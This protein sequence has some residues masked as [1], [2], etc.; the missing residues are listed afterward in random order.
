MSA[1][2][3]LIKQ[4]WS[5]LTKAKTLEPLINVLQHANV[6]PMIRLR[7]DAF[8]STDTIYL[9]EIFKQLRTSKLV[10]RSSFS[11]EDSA[12]TSMAGI[13]TSVTNV[14]NTEQLKNA[15]Q[16]VFNS[17]PQNFAHSEEVLIQ[18]MAK[19][20]A[21]CGVIFTQEQ[22]TSAPY[23]IISDDTSGQTDTVTSGAQGDIDTYYVRRGTEPRRPLLKLLL[24]L[25]N[26]LMQGFQSTTLDIEYAID[27]GGNVWLF[28]VRTLI[29]VNKRPSI[30]HNLVA[31]NNIYEKIKLSMQVHPFLFGSST[32]FGVMPDWNPAEI[33]GLYPKPLALSLYKS[34]ITDSTWAYQRHN[35]GYRNLRSFPLMVDFMG[36]PYIDVRVSF[37]SF[38]PKDISPALGNKLVDYYLEQLRSNPKSHDSVEF[39]IVL[40]C[41]TPSLENK[42]LNLQKHGFSTSQCSEISSHLRNLTNKIIDPRTGLWIQDLHRIEKLKQRY[43]QT[44]QGFSEPVSRIYWLLEDCKRYGTLPFA[45]LARAAFIAVQLM[46][47]ML[48]NKVLT[49]EEYH[50]FLGSLKTVSSKMQSDLTRLSKTQFLNEY[51]HL[52]PGTYDISSPRYDDAPEYYFDWDQFDKFEENDD[53]STYSEGLK[54]SISPITYARIEAMLTEHGINHSADSLLHFI[55]SA[56]EGREY[57]KFIFTRSLSDAMEEF[58]LLGEQLGFTRNQMAFSNINIINQL[59][60]GCEDHKTVI[61]QSIH[62]GENLYKTAQSIKLPTLICTPSD[63]YEFK[64]SESQPNFITQMNVTASVINCSDKSNLVDKI[65]F[66]T[67]AD[68]GYDWIFSHKIKGFVTAFGG[69][70]SHMAI[71]AAELNIP[72]VIGVGEPNFELWGQAEL[73]SIDCETNV[74]RIIK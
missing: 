71:R 33:I 2:I 53:P 43:K 14:L 73:L 10:V 40:S 32:V 3:A 68:P 48:E 66:I 46:Q 58:V 69:C 47:S 72:A 17:Y 60:T 70:N 4:P 11:Q 27:R 31:T 20:I 67:S 36:I 23:F 39:D 1:N 38:L 15:I 9:Q 74:V 12:Q 29:C 19:D 55:K 37:N 54:N 30:E 56:I 49:H 25:A 41:Y 44:I 35:Y 59:M 18:P 62:H 24:A 34:L 28:Q 65:V 16:K 57:A 42:L 6:L 45:G 26:E 13:F 50:G 52:R 61:Q 7:Y 63:V 5:L 8:E 64:V 51:G 21:H 22:N